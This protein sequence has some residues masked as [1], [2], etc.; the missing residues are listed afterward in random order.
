MDKN[1]IIDS[2]E[3]NE[4]YNSFIYCKKFS[5]NPYKKNKKNFI[6]WKIGFLT[7]IEIFIK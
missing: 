6:N 4:G 5:D 2:K 7:A 3:F 1:I